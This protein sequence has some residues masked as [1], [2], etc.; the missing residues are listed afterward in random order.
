MIF[1][2]NSSPV[3]SYWV[4]GSKRWLLS[5]IYFIYVGLA[6]VYKRDGTGH[7]KTEN[8]RAKKIQRDEISV[9]RSKQYIETQVKWC[10][11]NKISILNCFKSLW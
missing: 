5:T 4:T 9:T 6:S 1:L 7:E 10:Y 2:A 11:K 3:S 8:I